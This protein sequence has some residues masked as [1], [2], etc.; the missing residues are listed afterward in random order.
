MK[1]ISDPQMNAAATMKAMAYSGFPAS[2]MIHLYQQ[3]KGNAAEAKYRDLFEEMLA[4]GDVPHD[5][6]IIGPA[7]YF[8]DLLRMIEALEPNDISVDRKLLVRRPDLAA[9]PMDDKST[10]TIQPYLALVN[11]MVQAMA[12]RLQAAR[13]DAGLD[14]VQPPNGFFEPAIAK[15]VTYLRDADVDYGTL[16]APFVPDTGQ[17]SAQ[18]RAA[19]LGI[20]L[21]LHEALVNGVA[22]NRS[23]IETLQ[24]DTV[25]GE[26]TL[27]GFPAFLMRLGIRRDVV[28]MAL[29]NAGKSAPTAKWALHGG[30]TQHM[31]AWLYL[32]IKW[33]KYWVP[34]Q[35]SWPASE[36]AAPTETKV[37]D[38]DAPETYTYVG[39]PD[40]TKHA[41]CVIVAAWLRFSKLAD[42]LDLSAAD[43]RTLC[44]ALAFEDLDGDAI[45]TMRRVQ[46][47][48]KRFDLTLRDAA[49]IFGGAPA[50]SLNV[51]TDEMT[52][53]E[54]LFGTTPAV[55]A[56]SLSLSILTA[57][58]AKAARISAS[59]AQTVLLAL[60]V[61]TLA[62]AGDATANTNVMTAE[63]DKPSAM[64]L[65]YR[66]G[67]LSALLDQPVAKLVALLLQAPS[68]VIADL[69]DILDWT[70][71][72]GVTL[73][74]VLA[75]IQPI[76]AP[77]CRGE[78]VQKVAAALRAAP[79]VTGVTAKDDDPLNPALAGLAAFYGL[80]HDWMAHIVTHL[81][82][83]TR[84]LAMV[85]AMR[86][87]S[88][89][90]DTDGPLPDTEV[91]RTFSALQAALAMLLTFRP[92]K[93][94]FED[95]ELAAAFG[96]TINP[97]SPWR[98]LD[99]LRRLHL[100]QKLSSAR[101]ADIARLMK[102]LIDAKTEDEHLQLAAQIFGIDQADLAILAHDP[103]AGVEIL[104]I[105]TRLEEARACCKTLGIT[106]RTASEM[107][108]LVLPSLAL[109]DI[110]NAAAP[111]QLNHADFV[112]RRDA[113]AAIA[114]TC[115]N[116]VQASVTA[117][118]WQTIEDSSQRYLLEIERDHLVNS[119]LWLANLSDCV[120]GSLPF[121][122]PEIARDLSDALLV[123]VEMGGT[124][125]IS[126]LKLGLNSLQRFVQRVQSGGEGLPPPFHVEKSDWTWRSHYR[127]WEAN[128]KVFLFP[129]NYLDPNL[130]RRKTPLF[131]ELEDALLQGEINT[132]SVEQAYLAYVD[133]LEAL[134][135][136]TIVSSIPAIV[137]SEGDQSGQNTLFFLGRGTG[138]R[139]P[140]YLR[141]AV[142]DAQD[143]L[144]YWEPWTRI[145]LP[146]QSDEV[147]LGYTRGRVY[148]YWLESREI[149]DRQGEDRIS[150][151]YVTLRYT[152]QL[153]GGGWAEAR[154]VDDVKDAYAGW[155]L[156]HKDGSNDTFS[157]KPIAGFTAIAGFPQVWPLTGAVQSDIS[158]R[159]YHVVTTEDHSDQKPAQTSKL[160]VKL[161]SNADL[162]MTEADQAVTNIGMANEWPARYDRTNEFV[163]TWI[164]H[165]LAGVDAKG[166]TEVLD[167]RQCG[168]PSAVKQPP[169]AALCKSGNDIHVQLGSPDGRTWETWAV[170]DD[171]QSKLNTAQGKIVTVFGTRNFYIPLDGPEKLLRFNPADRTVTIVPWV[172][173]RTASIIDMAVH[174]DDMGMSFIVN[175]DRVWRLMLGRG[176]PGTDLTYSSTPMNAISDPPWI[177]SG[178]GN[179]VVIGGK[180]AYEN[181]FTV[182][183]YEIGNADRIANAQFAMD[184]ESFPS[185]RARHGDRILFGANGDLWEVDASTSDYTIRPLQTCN[186]DR[187]I[188]DI[189]QTRNGAA[190]AIHHSD[191][192]QIWHLYTQDPVTKTWPDSSENTQITGIS[193]VPRAVCPV[194]GSD[195]L[196]LGS[197]IFGLCHMLPKRS[198][199]VG[200]TS[201]QSKALF[202]PYIQM[203]PSGSPNSTMLP[204]STDAVDAL[205][206]I[207]S[208][209][210]LE[211]LLSLKTQ[212]SAI[213]SGINLAD[214]KGPINFDENTPYALYFREMYFHI[215]YLLATALNQHK[216]FEDAQSW[217][218][219]IFRPELQPSFGQ[220][221]DPLPFWRFAPFKTCK[222]EHLDGFKPEEYRLYEEDPFDA[223]AIAA[224]RM[225]AYE[226]AVVMRYIDNLLDWGDSLF[227]QD[228]WESLTRAMSLYLHASDLLGPDPRTATGDG[229]LPDRKTYAQAKDLP[230]LALV[231]PVDCFHLGDQAVFPIP[232]NTGFGDYWTRAKDRIDKIRA[233]KNLAGLTRQ[234]ALFQPPIDP[235][236]IMAALAAGEPL[237]QAVKAAG[238]SMP[239]HRF[240][241]LC[242]RAQSSAQ[243]V[244][245]LSSTLLSALERKDTEELAVLRAKHQTETLGAETARLDL[246]QA[247]A[248][249]RL[250]ALNTRKSDAD[251]KLKHVQA[252]RKKGLI[253]SEKLSV[254]LKVDAM[255]YSQGTAAIRSASAIGY[256]APCIFGFSDGGEDIGHMIESS[257]AALDALSNASVQGATLADARAQND[258]RVEDWDWQ[259]ELAGMEITQIAD[260]IAAANRALVRAQ[261][262][263]DLHAGRVDQAQATASY[264]ET[265]FSNS[266]L[267]GWLSGQLSTLVN[268]A[269]QQAVKLAEDA[270]WAYRWETNASDSFI[271]SHVLTGPKAHFLAGQN[272]L[273]DLGRLQAAYL[274]AAQSHY[275]IE[276][277]VS[278]V[279]VLADKSLA[280][281]VFKD[282][283]WTALRDG[284]TGTALSFSLPEAVFAGDGADGRFRRIRSISVTLPAV[285]GPYQSINAVLTQTRYQRKTAD[286]ADMVQSGQS[287]AISRGVDDHGVFD[288]DFKGDTYQPFEGTGAVSDWEIALTKGVS[289][290]IRDSLSDVVL[291]IR[292]TA[293]P[294]AG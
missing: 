207:L 46:V 75:I 116:A 245:T 236:Q 292:Y 120:E 263:L 2:S 43:T 85:S 159:L 61:R 63:V 240:E 118:K 293:A 260:E 93:A 246:A 23:L 66:L 80:S 175:F 137:K 24:S 212:T 5:R 104:S 267:Y 173:P 235:R 238:G 62:D 33:G 274:D 107:A 112:T 49:I 15:A 286:G 172:W 29:S 152:H 132:D 179:T 31:F 19:R 239:V 185:G 270:Q 90:I 215:P 163:L 156:H 187:E 230:G 198:V 184:A 10:N 99:T 4:Q 9:I 273:M 7:A 214:P 84:V 115:R 193:G 204:V 21:E 265:K 11:P 1:H 197:P 125:K 251:K 151:T 227:A 134:S 103:F 231:D 41:F 209:K 261:K 98:D 25:T 121:E 150:K 142:F 205:S 140:Y 122:T 182:E 141:S 18:R 114:E 171:I 247:D 111:S 52:E 79:D 279:T 271:K 73:D 220:D 106:P 123:D 257:A 28:D 94:L 14:A 200:P 113:R 54:R 285:V 74:E 216:H 186:H 95:A 294:I 249:A 109:S 65:M 176:K 145:D 27:Q 44:T 58:T 244:V 167:L 149:T 129:E 105:L 194:H 192:Q 222:L 165:D 210:G 191:S 183:V 139:P 153:H 82:D 26:V 97:A 202:N 110:S 211:A 284:D 160:H 254:K 119:V 162:M 203:M 40:P 17:A 280:K 164:D 224:I 166:E 102:R 199:H 89:A 128:R 77:T 138:E 258:R 181:I 91:L 268:T 178:P 3:L 277:S 259:I 283:D 287:V 35:G 131:E 101:K 276:R 190:I 195:Q 59:D 45:D 124:S 117:S 34:S 87:A 56:G 234:L 281:A 170:D 169:L 147:A 242:S 232:A 237:D 143:T 48:A 126:A 68:I 20:T 177:V 13:S 60:A 30:T 155:V 51:F 92:S 133:K 72:A 196:F 88:F 218:H 96:F 70:T 264:I 36:R 6:S 250:D 272:L 154:T 248:A 22:M 32:T 253:E 57:A 223:H 243:E 50:T 71:E 69:V 157:D 12:D 219:H 221:T 226:K 53:H 42:V 288:L 64:L 67:R 180:K 206:H 16:V 37:G 38:G 262:E 188:K 135:K 266:A 282:Q 255:S 290:E 189:R 269:Y 86:D 275:Q 39:M 108:A 233:S 136:L 161:Y 158:F 81:V 241:R 47:L 148:I 289:T 130:R 8:F 278:L 225:G 217:F 78:D 252:T 100:L 291:K 201:P 144:L 213:Q 168:D 256:A 83:Q 208:T 146:I 229:R 174:D 228:N 55:D 76:T 127:L